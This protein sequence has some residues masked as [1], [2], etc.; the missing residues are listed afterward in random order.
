MNI[1]FLKKSRPSSLLVAKIV[2]AAV[3][4]FVLFF[5]LNQNFAFTGVHRVTISSFTDLPRSVVYAG[6][7]DVGVVSTP[8]G[9]RTRPY[10]DQVKFAVTLPRGF[11]T[12]TMTAEVDADPYATLILNAKAAPTNNQAVAF[13]LP[14]AFGSDWRST[15]LDG[16]RLQLRKHENVKTADEFW[17]AIKTFRRVYTVGGDLASLIP[18][19]LYAKSA[20]LVDIKLAADY[21]GALIISAYLDSGTKGIRFTKKDLNFTVG[22]DTLRFTL[23]R[24]GKIFAT[25]NVGDDTGQSQD[26]VV[27]LPELQGGFYTLRFMPNNEDSLV[28]NIQFRGAEVLIQNR[29]FL[30]QV[31]N[32]VS[33]YTTCP[34]FTAEAVHDLGLKSS[35]TINGR[36]VTLKTVKKAQ[37]VSFT[38]AVGTIIIPRG[39]VSLT[40]SCGFQLKPEQPIR[41]AFNT[42]TKRIVPLPEFTA[43]ALKNAEAVFDDAQLVQTKTKSGYVIEKTFDLHKLSAKG[44]TFTFSLE[45][46]GLTTR[47]GAFLHIKKITFTAK[48]PTFSFSDIGRAFK[49][50]AK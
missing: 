10:T 29:I 47:P 33:L 4:V 1:S 38:G 49:A 16:G 17:A 50:L 39:D 31:T 25:K 43:A 23:E 27:T 6:G 7:A 12:M 24:G 37:E 9:K 28:R 40:S 3:P 20:Q 46:P 19:N 48:R 18:T 42:L 8:D 41:E 5:I 26:V 36:K 11:D 22:A 30:G 15:T 44:K 21:R 14:T 35:L 34:T 13:R 32:P 2:L 45:S